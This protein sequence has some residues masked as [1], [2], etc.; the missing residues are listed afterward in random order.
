MSILRCAHLLERERKTRR[1]YRFRVAYDTLQVAVSKN[2][3]TI[4]EGSKYTCI[5][6]INRKRNGF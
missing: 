2:K 4:T 1:C 5:Y 3:K 6:K